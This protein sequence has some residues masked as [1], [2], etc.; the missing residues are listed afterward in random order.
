MMM[1]SWDDEYIVNVDNDDVENYPFIIH[2]G[3]FKKDDVIITLGSYMTLMLMT[4][5]GKMRENGSLC[6]FIFQSTHLPMVME[7][8]NKRSTPTDRLIFQQNITIL[9]NVA[10]YDRNKNR[11]HFRRSHIC[12]THF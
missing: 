3:A 8:R 12:R 2:G 1:T 10:I 9:A 6:F 7:S 11:L 4:M 5:K